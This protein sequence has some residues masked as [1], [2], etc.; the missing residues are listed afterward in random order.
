MIDFLKYPSLTNHYAISKSSRLTSAYYNK[1][2]LWYSTEKIDGT[3]FSVHIS[4]DDV[5]FGKRSS[6]I[7]QDDKPFNNGISIVNNTDLVSF[8]QENFLKDSNKVLHLYGELYGSKIQKTNYDVAKLGKND[9]KFFDAIIETE[10]HSLIQLSLNKLKYILSTVPEMAT[11]TINT[12][13]LSELL[14]IIPADKSQYGGMSE[15]VV[16]KPINSNVYVETT[17]Y[18]GI[19]YKT[20]VFAEV[21]KI[22][23]RNKEKTIVPMNVHLAISDYVTV[24]RLHN[25][26]SKGDITLVTEN[27]GKLIVAMKN[28]IKIEYERENTQIDPR[29]LDKAVNSLSGSIANIV[30]AEMQFK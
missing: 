13:T 24:N 20:A 28:D 5:K 10:D 8:V 22:P 25:V 30:K 1:N 11:P 7:T 27:L 2:Q 12:G 26:L 14:E 9:L 23:M 6:F 29:V 19:K 18:L 4:K 17:P 15:G 16:L 21:K 3:N